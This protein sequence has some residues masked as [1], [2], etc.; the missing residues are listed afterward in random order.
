[1]IVSSLRPLCDFRVPGEGRR[2]PGEAT[3]RGSPGGAS[4]RS[5]IGRPRSPPI[6]SASRPA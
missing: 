2:C 1:M 3:W 4:R 5:S 6:S